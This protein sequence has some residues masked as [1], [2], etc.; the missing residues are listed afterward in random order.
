MR[1]GYGHVGGIDWGGYFWTKRNLP[2]ENLMPK[3]ED[4]DIESAARRLRVK[5]GI[6]EQLRPD[7]VTVIVKLKDR[8]LIKN[9]VRVPDEEMPDD[10][11]CFDSDNKLLY[12]RES[13]FCA[14]NALYTH[15]ETQRRHARFTIAHEIGHIALGHVGR[16]FRGATSAKAKQIRSQVSQ[17]ERD[18]D[19]FSA[20]FLAPAH[21][22]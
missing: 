13:T 10:E 20:A 3:L 15:T 11:A 6:D 18:A 14:A 2:Q 17:D 12:I 1:L 19:R 5:L 4:E 8:G 21:L 7:M 9:Y 22:A 16:H